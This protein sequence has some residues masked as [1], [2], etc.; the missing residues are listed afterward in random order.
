LPPLPPHPPPPPPPPPP[1][2]PAT[3]SAVPQIDV[4]DLTADED[5]S[6]INPPHISSFR[7]RRRRQLPSSFGGPTTRRRRV[8]GGVIPINNHDADEDED[9]VILLPNQSR[10]NRASR[11][12]RFGRDI[13][14]PVD[15]DVVDLAS[16]PSPTTAPSFQQHQQ[17]QQQPH[18]RRQQGQDG[19][20]EATYGSRSIEQQLGYDLPSIDLTGLGFGP[21]PVSSREAALPAPAYPAATQTNGLRR[22]SSPEVTFIRAERR[23]PSRGAPPPPPPPPLP[24]NFSRFA[25]PLSYF[26]EFGRLRQV[27]TGTLFN[28]ANPNVLRP[29]GTSHRDWQNDQLIPTW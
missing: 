13:I 15:V 10:R 23:D 9:E 26:D 5:T 11:P 3:A 29:S 22:E 18:Q 19:L 7:R 14:N 27:V 17:Q 1:P 6:S 21:Q 4:I 20:D 25:H 8:D 24:P 28:P 12:P 2:L 16:P